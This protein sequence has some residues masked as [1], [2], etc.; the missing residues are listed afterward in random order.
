MKLSK[1]P[2]VQ[3]S[4]DEKIYARL[5]NSI[6]YFYNAPDFHNTALKTPE[7]WKITNFSLS[8]GQAPLH[9][10]AFIPCITNL[11]FS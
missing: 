6:I 1:T 4:N 3:F 8:T 2:H 10:A 9:I 7:T 11:Q 5:N